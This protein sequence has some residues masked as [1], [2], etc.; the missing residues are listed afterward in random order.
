MADDF[1][2]LPGDVEEW[3]YFSGTAR[4]S[5]ERAQVLIARLREIHQPEDT[6]AEFWSDGPGEDEHDERWP[7]CEAVARSDDRFCGG[8]TA[9]V[10][11]CRECGFE[12]DDGVPVY[13]PWP[14]PT[15]Q[16]VTEAENS[17][18]CPTCGGVGPDRADEDGEGGV[19]MACGDDWH[20]DQAPLTDS[21][22]APDGR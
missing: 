3:R 9:I 1:D 7:E 22:E 21:R 5:D 10:P 12:H 2:G 4:R 18:R 20:D 6:E 15:I 13:R 16:A 8:H 17:D 19:E 14:C 11:V